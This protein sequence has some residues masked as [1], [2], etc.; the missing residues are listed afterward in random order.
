[1]TV[2]QFTPT[3]LE[4]YSENLITKTI[5][6]VMAKHITCKSKSEITEKTRLGRRK[7]DTMIENGQI[8]YINGLYKVQ[9]N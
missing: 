6:K 7:I 5:E 8:E 9:I 2:I 4:K 3:E 1:M